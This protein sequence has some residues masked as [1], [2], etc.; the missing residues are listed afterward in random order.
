MVALDEE[1]Y[2]IERRRQAVLSYPPRWITIGVTSACTNRCVFC[3]YHSQDAKNVSKVYGLPFSMNTEAFDKIVRMAWQARVP[4]VH[5]CGTGEPFMNREI[6]EMIDCAAAL[7]GK[8][9]LQTN[10]NCSLFKKYR[11]L[12]EIVD[13]A[14]FISFITTDFLSGDPLHHNQLKCGSSYIDI[15]NSLK[16]ISNNSCINLNIHYILTRNNYKFFLRLLVDLVDNGIKNFNINVV[17][18]FSYNFNL[19]T[20]DDSVYLSS[21]FLIK[22]TLDEAMVFA[23]D[24]CIPIYLPLPADQWENGCDVFWQK[25]QIWPVQGNDPDRFAENMVPHACRAVVLGEL[26][27]LGYIFDYTDLM[28]FWN[29]PGLVKIRRNLINGVYPDKQCRH[30]YCYDKPDSYYREKLS[31]SRY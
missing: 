7:Y 22:D 17:N 19:F 20:S 13:R 16:F 8:V 29:N 4:R 3:S 14:D 15:M 25:V 12:D 5:I 26:S 9:S 11:Y 28:D 6:L 21:D 27:S 24:N 10:F 2:S 31:G 1:R 30:C 23:K 18:L